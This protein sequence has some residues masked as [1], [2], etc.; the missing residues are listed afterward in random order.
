MIEMRSKML[1][2]RLI[3]EKTILWWLA[4]IAIIAISLP[5]VF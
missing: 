2:M 4:L 1:H 3:F 5:K